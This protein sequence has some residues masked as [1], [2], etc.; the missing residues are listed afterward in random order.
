M[1]AWVGRVLGTLAAWCV[2]WIVEVARRGADLPTAAVGWGTGAGALALLTVLAGAVAVLAPRVLRRPAGG[3]TCSCLLV[4]VVVVRPP[5]P[6]WP[7]DGW[8]LVACDVGQGDA[9]VL[10][11]GP[12]AAVI[13]DA[14]PDPPL[15]DSCL[16]RLGVTRVPLLVLT[17]FH[18]DHVDGLGGVLAG[19]S[20]AELDVSP[21]ADPPDGVRLVASEAHA[22]GLEPTVAPYAT[23][24]RVG[25]VS[26]QALW[27]L[28]G[29]SAASPG[30]GSDAN[31]ASVVLLVEVAGVRVLLTGDVEPEAQ[32]ALARAWPGLQVD[33]L[34]VPHHG[35]R[36]QDADFLTGLGARLALV[37][38]GADN[39]Y[40]HP[41]PETLGLLREA[42]ADVLRTDQ[43]GDIAVVEEGGDLAAVTAR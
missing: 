22:A 34:K 19:R 40:G 39:D 12:G 24:R 36:Y 18:A 13:V 43:D 17:H 6:G 3:I 5:T 11:A 16:D 20:V 14:G 23:G 37:S 10:R 42:G 7:P 38:A 28:P 4:A 9:I 32:Q 26:I 25:D 8:V 29:A 1:W 33:V 27:P 21:V 2:A 35:S 15:V 41:A 31:D 30:D